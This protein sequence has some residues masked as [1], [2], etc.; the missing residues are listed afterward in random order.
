MKTTITRRDLAAVLAL[1]AG[2]RSA[3][4]QTPAQ[5]DWYREARDS[6]QSAAAELAKF[7]LPAATEP[8][9]RFKA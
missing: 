1:A 2:A 5:R 8:A 3:G 6:K 7:E 9:F 4:A